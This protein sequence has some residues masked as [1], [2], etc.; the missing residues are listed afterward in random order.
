MRRLTIALLAAGT[1]VAAHAQ[2]RD[3]VSFTSGAA[4]Q[5]SFTQGMAT[6]SAAP[7]QSHRR[8]IDRPVVT[9]TTGIRDVVR[10]PRQHDNR[11]RGGFSVG[12]R[13]CYRG[14]CGNTG[15][16][17]NPYLYAMPV[18]VERYDG[19]DFNNQ[20]SAY[21]IYGG[22]IP[23]E[24]KAPGAAAVEAAYRQGQL[25][26]RVTSLAE[27]VQRLR[28][29]KAARESAETK[30]RQTVGESFANAGTLRGEAESQGRTTAATATLVFKSGRRLDIGNYAVVGQ[31]LWVF[32]E[33]R[34]RRIPLTDLDLAATQRVNAEHGIEFKLPI[35]TR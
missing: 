22:N 19:P 9:P 3:S 30:S 25:E 17:Y 32:D 28:A 34:A 26:A 11:F 16:F 1:I 23:E 4:S 24:Y 18:Y 29:E 35:A 13:G 8:H 33:V 10:F 2:N 12:A 15:Y 27:E 21:T 5:G 20:P 6:G 31:T 7:A 14:F